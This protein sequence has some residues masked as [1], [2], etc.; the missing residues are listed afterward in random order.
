MCQVY[1]MYKYMRIIV[2]F[3]LPV[4]S[5]KDRKLATKFRKFLLDDRYIM[6]QFSIYSRICKNN[7]DLTK[8]I[9]RIKL[10]APKTGNIRLLSVTEAQYNNMIMIFGEKSVNENIGIDPL[11]IL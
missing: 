7:D 3:D 4:V 11:I 10:K 9:N 1:A 5:E 8:H 2:M 6:M